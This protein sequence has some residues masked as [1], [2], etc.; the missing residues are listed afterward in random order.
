[1]KKD[2][3]SFSEELRNRLQKK[4]GGDLEIKI[5]EVTKNNG[6]LYHGLCMQAKDCNIAPTIYIDRYYQEYRND[7]KGFEEI[8][9]E[10]I[11][12]YHNNRIAKS[13]DVEGLLD[14]E[15]I[16][17]KIICELIN[18]EQNKEQLEQIP[19]I[20]YHDLAIV[21]RIL[22]TLDDK[23]TGT[24]LINHTHRAM[25]KNISEQELYDL[26][27]VNTKRL[28]GCKICDITQ[29]L[30]EHYAD[31]EQDMFDEMFTDVVP[32]YVMSNDHCFKGAASLLNVERLEEF[33]VKHN[34]DFYILPSSIHEIILLPVGTSENT[35]YLKD[36]V[37]QINHS[38]VSRED[39]LSNHIYFYALGSKTVSI[40]A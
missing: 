3:N 29:I 19:Y 10:I 36:M 32:M 5:T 23:E 40:V 9:D 27:I 30:K 38:E 35:E 28:L 16:K 24:I 39:R 8:L 17:D 21:F 14:F 20:P 11:D 25:W 18:Y 15:N 1:M 13:V 2:F 22:C 7:L 31:M 4:M 37:S 33:A 34:T 12:I 26:A 6:Q